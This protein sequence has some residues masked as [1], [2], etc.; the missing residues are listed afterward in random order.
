[1]FG[2]IG[3]LGLVAVLQ[4]S[5]NVKVA[6]FIGGQMF[7]CLV[8]AI[9]YATKWPEISLAGSLV[10]S[11]FIF[12]CCISLGI[13]LYYRACLLLFLAGQNDKAF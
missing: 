4:A 5:L 11:H 8:G 13:L 2:C 10:H 12:H 9:F 6:A 3:V 7:A 1:M